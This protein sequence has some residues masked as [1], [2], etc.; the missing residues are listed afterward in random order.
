MKNLLSNIA[1]GSVYFTMGNLILEAWLKMDI[2]HT[3]IIPQDIVLFI[4]LIGGYTFT[5]KIMKFLMKNEDQ[6]KANKELN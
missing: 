6:N 5:R 2:K 1:E 3:T 4:M